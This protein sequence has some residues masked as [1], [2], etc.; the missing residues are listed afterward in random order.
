VKIAT[1]L[2]FSFFSAL[3]DDVLGVV[4]IASGFA[5]F[6]FFSMES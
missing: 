1:L 6:I 3:I 5:F 2:T 4:T